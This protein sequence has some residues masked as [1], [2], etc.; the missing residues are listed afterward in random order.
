[1]RKYSALSL[2][3][4]G[5][6][7]DSGFKNVGFKTICSL[8]NSHDSCKTL[9]IN[10][11]SEVIINEDIE[12]IDNPKLKKL[13]GLK[14][15]ELDVVIG[16]P[17][18]PAFSKSRFYRKEKPRGM[19]D[20]S[21]ITLGEY[22]RVIDYFKPKYFVFENVPH[23]M[24]KRQK[25]AFE[26]ILNLIK[27]I[28][29]TAEFKVLNAANFGV[30]Q[31]RERLIIV[32][33][34]KGFGFTFPQETHHDSNNNSSGQ[35]TL[36]SNGKNDW[37]TSGMAIGDLDTEENACDKGHYAGGQHHDLLCEIPPGGNYLFF[38]EKKGHP[39][40]K[41]EWRSRYWSFLLKLS[42]NLP[43]WTIQA[44]RSNNMGPFHWRNRILRIEEVKRLQTFNDSYRFFGTVDS[45]WRQ[46]GNAVPPLLAKKI[47]ESIKL[48]LR[49]NGY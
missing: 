7:L 20:P 31:K 4:G 35:S 30:P 2:F 22:F 48:G 3:S 26:F 18:C 39:N 5:G 1:M 40:P 12:K 9:E 8:D 19:D 32:G 16:G 34:R 24:A 45:Q 28:G 14:K 10:K 47:A 37:I 42:Q 46:I 11:M 15:R 6:G 44:R 29:Y 13:T 38:T 36:F 27:E 25:G 43:S 49:Q 33:C 41:F 21:S 17:P 23:L